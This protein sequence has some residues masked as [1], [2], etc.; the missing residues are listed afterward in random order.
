MTK[1][2]MEK[3]CVCVFCARAT[4]DWRGAYIA[5]VCVHKYILNGNYN[6]KHE[7]ASEL[8][9]G[10]WWRRRRRSAIGDRLVGVVAVTKIDCVRAYAIL[11][12]AAVSC[13]FSP[14]SDWNKWNYAI[15]LLLLYLALWCFGHAK[16][17]NQLLRETYKSHVYCVLS[18]HC[19]ISYC[20]ILLPFVMYIQHRPTDTGIIFGVQRI[21]RIKQNVLHDACMFSFFFCLFVC[22]HAFR[23]RKKTKKQNNCQFIF[24][25]N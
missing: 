12:A 14:S 13:W 10:W 23:K 19:I 1:Y 5:G 4:M 16:A 9:D 24:W 20:V 11:S 17:A 2:K 21:L 8:G 25:S 6:L 3:C 15:M 18:L 22:L 7:W